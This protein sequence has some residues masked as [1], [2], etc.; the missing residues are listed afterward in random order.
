MACAT[1]PT[2]TDTSYKAGDCSVGGCISACS[3][4]S[5][6]CGN[7]CTGDCENGC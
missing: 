5:S 6:V 4:C 1:G 3:A 2:C 7:T